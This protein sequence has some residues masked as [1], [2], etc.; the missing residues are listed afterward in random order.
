MSVAVFFNW[1]STWNGVAPG[2][3]ANTRAA[4][5]LTKGAAIDVPSFTA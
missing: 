1:R 2:L 3:A 4:T 5:P